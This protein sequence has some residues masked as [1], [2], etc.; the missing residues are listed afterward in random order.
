MEHT[1]VYL[2]RAVLILLCYTVTRKRITV[3][4]RFVNVVFNVGWPAH[5][6]WLCT[7]Y[8]ICGTCDQVAAVG[9]A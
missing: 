4:L 5:S 6:C 2:L 9:G 3:K 1:N 7:I 8:T